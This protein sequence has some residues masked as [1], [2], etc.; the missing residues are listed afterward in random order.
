MPIDKAHD[1]DDNISC[2]RGTIWSW[3]KFISSGL[4]IHCIVN[5][6]V[7]YYICLK[8]Y[9]AHKTGGK[10]FIDAALFLNWLEKYT[11]FYSITKKNQKKRKTVLLQERTGKR[12][13]D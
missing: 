11:K 3:K 7:A 10:M 8:L 12:D 9:I 1:Y 6:Q 4:C 13:P 2:I 5:H